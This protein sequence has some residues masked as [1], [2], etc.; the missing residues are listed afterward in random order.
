MF[1]TNVEHLEVNYLFNL[2]IGGW[3]VVESSI[4]SK[5]FYIPKIVWVASR[6]ISNQRFHMLPEEKNAFTGSTCGR[7]DI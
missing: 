5:E 6:R 1:I 3:I 7:I 2:T 4:T